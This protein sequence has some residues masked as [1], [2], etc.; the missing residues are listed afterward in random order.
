[1]KK[2]AGFTLIELVV[3][4]VLMGIVFGTIIGLFSQSVKQQQAGV[5]Q[6]ELFSQARAMMAEIKTTLRYADKDSIKFYSGTTETALTADSSDFT[7]ITKMVYTSTIFSNNYDAANGTSEKVDVT[8]ALQQPSGWTH[9]QMKVTKTIGAITKTLV[10]PEKDA[11]SLF[12]T[13]TNFPISPAKLISSMDVE[14]YKIDLPMQYAISGSMK[15]EHLRTSVGP[16]T[17]DDATETDP[18]IIL[19]NHYIDIA[20]LIQ[21]YYAGETLTTD[22]Q[23]QVAVYRSY[24]NNSLSND[25]LRAYVYNV[26]YNGAWPSGKVTYANG[27]TATVYAQPFW[28]VSAT[29]DTKDT[30]I[31]CQESSAQQP[32]WYTKY[33]YNTDTSKLY[34]RSSPTSV[35]TWAWSTLK[36]TILGNGWTT[37]GSTTFTLTKSSI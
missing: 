26:Y 25:A 29:G 12:T 23:A 14:L 17:T 10:F 15:E 8:V 11:N 13:T 32:G 2:N 18:W 16:L 33:I 1:M 30:F 36:D 4:I 21:K 20:N 34:I 28:V 22:E 24:G 31:F 3:A 7:G 37:E 9:K 6:Q 35:N 5:S 19:R 27:I